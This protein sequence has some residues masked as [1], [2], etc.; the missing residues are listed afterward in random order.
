MVYFSSE[1]E[2]SNNGHNVIH[3]KYWE[4]K[5]KILGWCVEMWDTFNSILDQGVSWN[6]DIDEDFM[7]TEL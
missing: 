5:G 3:K 4:S 7:H 2:R 6:P 1:S